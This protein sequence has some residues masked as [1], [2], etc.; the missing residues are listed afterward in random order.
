MLRRR[1]REPSVSRQE[2]RGEHMVLDL[3]A[4]NMCI[5]DN[6]V[7]DDS[8]MECA[9]ECNEEHFANFGQQ[10]GVDVWNYTSLSNNILKQV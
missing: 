4:L 10:G 1:G 6:T 5:E 7:C 3:Q 8:V 9:K 2:R